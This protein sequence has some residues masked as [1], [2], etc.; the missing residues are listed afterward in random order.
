MANCEYRGRGGTT[1]PF[2]D[3]RITVGVAKGLTVK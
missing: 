1:I 3:A 2:T